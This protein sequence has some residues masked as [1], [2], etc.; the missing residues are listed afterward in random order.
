MRTAVGY[1]LFPTV[2]VTNLAAP[3]TPELLFLLRPDMVLVWRGV[4]YGF[5][6]CIVSAG[7]RS[8]C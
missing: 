5:G 8:S 1:L 2:E 6:V 7:S 3:V 4:W